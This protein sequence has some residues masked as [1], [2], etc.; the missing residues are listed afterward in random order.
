MTIL[1][2]ISPAESIGPLLAAIVAGAGIMALARRDRRWRLIGAAVAV[3]LLLVPWNG[4]LSALVMLLGTTNGLSAATLIMLGALAAA[5]VS[6][7]RPGAFQSPWL[8]LTVILLGAALFPAA[9]LAN[10]L[11]PYE[12]GY[13]GWMLPAILAAV[14]VGNVVAWRDPLVFLWIALG[15]AIWALSLYETANLWDTLIDPV[16]VIGAVLI[17]AGRALRRRRAA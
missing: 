9:S 5:L 11:D 4:R 17:L 7:R 2:W 16:A 3:V 10:H 6:G 12:W 14:F 15:A 8:A 13:S 1:P